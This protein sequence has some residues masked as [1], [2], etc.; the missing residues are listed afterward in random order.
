MSF[1]FPGVESLQYN[2][3]R[4]L[5]IAMLSRI[6]IKHKFHFIERKYLSNK[7]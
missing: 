7:L 4:N 2:K 5:I 6:V 1:L 3:Q